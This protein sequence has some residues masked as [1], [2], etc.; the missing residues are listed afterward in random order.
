MKANRN[1]S[2]A[3]VERFYSARLNRIIIPS[4]A[5]DLDR[6]CSSLFELQV[7]HRYVFIVV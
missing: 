2:D 5:A 3:S 4:D 7:V 1:F 6:P